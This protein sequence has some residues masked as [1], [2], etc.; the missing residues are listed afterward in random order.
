MKS[1]I[2][3]LVET[4]SPSG[5]EAQI[6]NLIRSEVEVHGQAFE[7]IVLLQRR[8]VSVGLSGKIANEYRSRR[9]PLAMK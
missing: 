8:V 4:P 9:K 2:Q 5:Y 7:A 1:L 3:K 6:R